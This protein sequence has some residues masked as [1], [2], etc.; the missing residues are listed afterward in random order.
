MAMEAEYVG[1]EEYV[2]ES[3]ALSRLTIK[4]DIVFEQ[5]RSFGEGVR[6]L[7]DAR[8]TAGRDQ[9]HAH[10]KTGDHISPGFPI[11]LRSPLLCS[12]DPKPLRTC[13]QS[14]PAASRLPA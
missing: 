6:N 13:S 10:L 7:E 9:G 8:Y 1:E 11:E 4:V 12:S 14:P 2:D 3:S 5:G